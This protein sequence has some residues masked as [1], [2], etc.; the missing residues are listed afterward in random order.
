MSLKQ[1]PCSTN[2]VCTCYVYTQPAYI[3]A[4]EALNESTYEKP[5]FKP[6]LLSITS[7]NNNRNL[8]LRSPTSHQDDCRSNTIARRPTRCFQPPW[9]SG[10][11]ESRRNATGSK[12]A[13]YTPC[14]YCSPYPR[15]FRPGPQTCNLCPSKRR[16]PTTFQNSHNLLSLQHLVQQYP[17]TPGPPNQIPAPVLAH[18]FYSVGGS[19]TPAMISLRN[20]ELVIESLK[21]DRYDCASFLLDYQPPLF[22]NGFPLRANPACYS[23]P[24]TLNFLLDRGASL[25]ANPLHYLAETDPRDPQ[26]FDVLAQRG[27]GIDSPLET[28]KHLPNMWPTSTPLQKACLF[29]QPRSAEALLRLGANPNGVGSRFFIHRV[30]FM[31]GY[32]YSSPHPILTLLLS[33]QWVSA[34]LSFGPRLIECFQLLLHYGA[35]TSIPLLR[36]DLLEILMLRIWRVLYTQVYTQATRGSN[37]VLPQ[38]PDRPGDIN[39]G[40]QSL[41]FALNDMDVSPWDHVCQV[42]SDILHGGAAL[43]V[44]K[45]RLIQLLG[46]YQNRFGDLPGPAQLQ[47]S[48]LLTLPDRYLVSE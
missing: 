10:S 1:C 34:D 2:L 26:V 45:E 16:H 14:F 37:F 28:L 20:W 33:T 13:L 38:V 18:D 21:K 23:S 44:G 41:L 4:N 11:I 22:P 42:F 43:P 8:F 15:A 36:G 3:K 5:N 48:S 46:D 12:T 25:G 40:V 19:H 35:T 31:S 6:L 32:Q 27:F 7:N 24:T 9:C 39:Q 17:L 30:P 47:Q 29:L